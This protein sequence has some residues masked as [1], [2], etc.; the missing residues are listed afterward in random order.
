MVKGRQSTW[1]RID[2]RTRDRFR[3]MIFERDAYECQIRGPGCTGKAEQLDH[4]VPR[5][6]DPSRILDPS[7]ARAACSICN[8]SRSPGTS[9]PSRSW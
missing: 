9:S 3:K 1:S 4:I 5:R 7:N 2:R 8:G 6:V